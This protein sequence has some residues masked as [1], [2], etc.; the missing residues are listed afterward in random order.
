MIIGT[1]ILYLLQVYLKE[2]EKYYYPAA[3]AGCGLVFAVFLYFAI[4]QL[5]TLLIYALFSFFGQA[6]VTETVQEARGWA[7]DLAWHDL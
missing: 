2:K 7:L 4:P 1:G 3:L 6:P 5:Y